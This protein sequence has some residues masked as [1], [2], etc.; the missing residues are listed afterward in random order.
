M[1]DPERP[2]VRIAGAVILGAATVSAAMV[3]LY[4]AKQNR[5]AETTSTVQT[6][7][8]EIDVLKQRISQDNEAIASRDA[9]IAQLRKH[10]VA[11]PDCPPVAIPPAASE[12]A[13]NEKSAVAAVSP[14]TIIRTVLEREV[15]FSLQ[16]CRLSGTTFTCNFLITSKGADRGIMLHGY[17]TNHS[18]VIDPAGR[19]VRASR[20]VAG[21]N[22]CEGGCD[23]QASLP[24]DVSI[25]AQVGFEGVQPG[26]KHVQL[27]EVACFI[28][29]SSGNNSHDIVVKFPNFDI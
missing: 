26:T 28:G 20:F 15:E 19:E 21:A 8:T 5:L 2:W 29:D 10:T 18:R 22:H 4:C 9:E 11:A 12:Q 14:R 27:L 25:A 24:A 23:V 13:T 1:P 16:G 6:S 3:P 7:R 17:N